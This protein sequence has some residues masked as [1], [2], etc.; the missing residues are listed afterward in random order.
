MWPFC[1]RQ[2]SPFLSI[3][4]RVFTKIHNRTAVTY[5]LLFQSYPRTK[6]TTYSMYCTSLVA[7]CLTVCSFFLICRFSRIFTIAQPSRTWFFSPPL[8]N[9]PPAHETHDLLHVPCQ[10]C[11]HENSLVVNAVRTFSL[12]SSIFT[13]IHNRT[14]TTNIVCV[15]FFPSSTSS[16]QSTGRKLTNLSSTQ[17]L[18]CGSRDLNLRT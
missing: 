18:N 5:I 7:I 14:A 6:L 8:S 1:R 15:G 3:N 12:P 17:Q 10:L 13:N 4:I 9:S 2:R 16:F 11:G